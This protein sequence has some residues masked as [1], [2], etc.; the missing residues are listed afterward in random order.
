MTSSSSGHRYTPSIGPALKPILKPAPTV[1]AAPGSLVGG[2][3]ATSDPSSCPICWTG[4]VEQMPS[5]SK[6]YE[7]LSKPQFGLRLEKIRP[8]KPVG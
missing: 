2:E 6:A 8:R 1:P 5:T 4:I 7:V 3:I